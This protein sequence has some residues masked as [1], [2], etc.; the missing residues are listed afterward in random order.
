MTKIQPHFKNRRMPGETEWR[1]VGRN[2]FT[3]CDCSHFFK[4]KNKERG[5]PSFAFNHPSSFFVVVFLAHQLIHTVV[6][7][8]ALP[9]RSHAER[10]I[11][12]YYTNLG[13][14]E[15]YILGILVY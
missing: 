6:P 5:H 14:N 1:R 13:R 7:Y 12:T 11:G 15:E 4:L 3:R 9:S 2:T 10:T 8:A